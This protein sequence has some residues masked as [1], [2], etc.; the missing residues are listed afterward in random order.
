MHTTLRSCIG[1]PWVAALGLGALA[2]AAAPYWTPGRALAAAAGLALGYGLAV[3]VA[4]HRRTARGASIAGCDHE[5]RVA[6]TVHELRTPLCS[7]ITALEMVRDGYATT[8]AEID[9]FV[10]Q[11]A[12]A[13]R[14]LAFLVNDV[15]DAAALSAG[16]L[17]LCPG[18]HAVR[19]LLAEAGRVLGL[20][21]HARGID[22]RLDAPA[23]N[24]RVHTDPRRCLQVVFNLVGNA[25]KFSDAGTRVVLTVDALPDRVRF[26]VADEGRGV[27]RELAERLFTRFARA[28]DATTA[29]TEGNGLGLHLCQR[30]VEQ[31]GGRI[32]H[33]P[34]SPRGAVFWFELPRAADGDA[35]IDVA[36]DTAGAR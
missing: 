30:L 20:Q 6:E 34:G 5:A 24:L 21:A 28:A 18:D 7:V 9:E 19:D 31:L 23:A 8:R 35:D 13:A 2:C 25:L 16:G 1:A 32:G 29:A 11:A 17:R 4:A 22:L 33:W 27:P 26:R 15:V 10:S 36:H 3:A 12:V 14:H